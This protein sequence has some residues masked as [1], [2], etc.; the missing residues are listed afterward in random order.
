MSRSFNQYCLL[1]VLSGCAA[2]LPGS[3]QLVTW[4]AQALPKAFKEAVKVLLIAACHNNACQG[5]APGTGTAA[6]AAAGTG[7]VGAGSAGA[8]APA[9]GEGASASSPAA[10]AAGK[11]GGGAAVD[12]TTTTGADGSSSSGGPAGAVA[13]A[14]AVVDGP[15]PLLQLPA[16]IWER[17]FERAAFP[18]SYWGNLYQQ[19]MAKEKKEE[20]GVRTITISRELQEKVA[21]QAAVEE[22]EEEAALGR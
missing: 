1:L 15:S 11:S 14:A 9:A 22:A 6:A 13:A 19:L 10:A 20:G 12:T 21:A 3:V 17:I 4:Y 8:A 7:E 5:L 16:V 2:R 18:L